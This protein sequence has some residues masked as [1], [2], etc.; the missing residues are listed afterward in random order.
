ME[1]RRIGSLEVSVVGLGGNNFGLSLDAAATAAVVNGALDAGIDFFDTAD[2]YGGRRSEELLGRAL[3]CRRDEAVIATKFGMPIDERLGG[4]RPEYVRQALEA[5]L[6]RLRTDRVELYQLHLPDPGVPVEE[7][8][9]VLDELVQAGKVREVGCSNHSAE[10]L[11]AAARAHAPGRARF[12]SVQNEYSLLQRE[13]ERSLLPE[14]ERQGVAF[15][16]YYPLAS[17]VLTGKYRRGVPPPEGSRFAAG[18]GGAASATE[19]TPALVE[20]LRRGELPRIPRRRERL[21][22]RNLRLVES[23][24]G[25]AGERGRTLL[26]LA[27][28]WLLSRPV[29]AS[30]IAGATRPEQVRANAAAAGWQLGP[31]ELAEVDAILAKLS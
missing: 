6:Q 29:V 14:C 13:V 27:F 17:G 12:A 19:L 31:A 16:P 1:R 10:Q 28:S 30:V 9:G 2:S 22:D 23:L 26:E 21:S 8:L 11:Q 7:T 4:G 24:T 5:S 18:S 15:L 3:R 25:F 20:S